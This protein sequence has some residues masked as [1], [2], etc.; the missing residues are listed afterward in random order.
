MPR[1][2]WRLSLGPDRILPLIEIFDRIGRFCPS[3]LQP[4][5]AFSV[6]E[7]LCGICARIEVLFA[8]MLVSTQ[9]AHPSAISIRSPIAVQRNGERVY[10]KSAQ[11]GIPGETYR[12]DESVSAFIFQEL[13]LVGSTGL[14]FTFLAKLVDPEFPARMHRN[15]SPAI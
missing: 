8:C 9:A 12:Y 13:W 4:R 15:L 1:S 3:F 14:L 11:T 7:C 10:P 6:S 2:A 5:L